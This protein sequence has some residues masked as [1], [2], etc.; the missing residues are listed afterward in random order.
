[1]FDVELSADLRT[2]DEVYLDGTGA[3]TTV[4]ASRFNGFDAPVVRCASLDTPIPFA[5]ELEK[6]Y[7]ALSRLDEKISFLLGY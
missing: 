1:M 6:N 7:M 2:G 4:Y 3:Y 5:I